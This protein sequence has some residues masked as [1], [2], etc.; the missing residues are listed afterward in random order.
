MCI[1]MS[2][3]LYNVVNYTYSPSYPQENILLVGELTCTQYQR[4]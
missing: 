3:R 2:Y 4:D 1:R